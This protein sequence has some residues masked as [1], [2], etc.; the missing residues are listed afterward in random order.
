M[1]KHIKYSRHARRRMNLYG[2]TQEDVSSVLEYQNPDFVFP[3]GKNEI[4]SETKLSKH[5][6]RIK[7][8]FSCEGGEIVVITAYPLKKG[9][10]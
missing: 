9:L 4:I 3:Q 8:V 2:L 6:Y 5:G 7:I 10:R 1:N